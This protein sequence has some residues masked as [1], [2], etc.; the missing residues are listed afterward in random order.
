MSAHDLA[1]PSSQVKKI[2]FTTS[3]SSEAGVPNGVGNPMMPM[4]T[5]GLKYMGKDAARDLFCLCSSSASGTGDLQHAKF[6]HGGHHGGHSFA[7]VM[8][9]YVRVL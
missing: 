4:T 2:R 7:Q 9:I 6:A 1:S 8:L 5:I 3:G